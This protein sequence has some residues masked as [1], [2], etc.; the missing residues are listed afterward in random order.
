MSVVSDNED[1][2]DSAAE[3][4]VV[5]SSKRA[6][7]DAQDREW[8][9]QWI[10]KSYRVCRRTSGGDERDESESEEEE[11]EKTP[12]KRVPRK[13]PKKEKSRKPKETNGA[14]PQKSPTEEKKPKTSCCEVIFFLCFIAFTT[15]MFTFTEQAKG[16]QL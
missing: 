2:P 8:R 5:N 16:G 14:T 11:R 15:A 6:R 7:G 4:V 13:E 3:K 12:P 10:A 1:R 9:K